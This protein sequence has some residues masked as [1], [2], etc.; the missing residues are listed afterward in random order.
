MARFAYCHPHRA[1]RALLRAFGAQHALQADALDTRHVTGG[2]T[3]RRWNADRPLG[4]R[5]A[6][7]PGLTYLVTATLNFLL[8]GADALLCRLSWYG[9]LLLRVVAVLPVPLAYVHYRVPHVLRYLPMRHS[10]SAAPILQHASILCLG[11]RSCVHR[12]Y[13]TSCPTKIPY[14]PLLSCHGARGTLGWQ[15][16]YLKKHACISLAR[17]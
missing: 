3:I 7:L 9:Y 2:P 14:A 5:L 4:S 8:R 16:M 1:Y 11:A 13:V 6:T 12:L 17:T 15:T 10:S